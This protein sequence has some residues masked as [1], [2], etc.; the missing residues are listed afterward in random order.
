MLALYVCEVVFKALEGDILISKCSYKTKD[1]N[2]ALS[3][4]V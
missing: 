4:Y 3:G 1:F 2:P